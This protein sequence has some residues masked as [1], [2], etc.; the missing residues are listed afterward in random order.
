MKY[1]SE[2]LSKKNHTH[3]YCFRKNKES[4]KHQKQSIHKSSH[5]F[6]S[7]ISGNKRNAC[8]IYHPLYR[9]RLYMHA[10]RGVSTNKKGGCHFFGRLCLIRLLYDYI[11]SPLGL[12]LFA[13]CTLP[14]E[15]YTLFSAPPIYIYILRKNG[16]QFPPVVT[17][18]SRGSENN[19]SAKLF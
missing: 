18:I 5:H 12:A 6:S 2:N 16:F 11:V 13:P 14:I 7:T 9:Y 15:K 8:W 1:N 10:Q 17:V 19:A 3:L 4:Y